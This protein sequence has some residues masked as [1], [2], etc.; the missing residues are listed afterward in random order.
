VLIEN[1]NRLSIKAKTLFSSKSL[2]LIVAFISIFNILT[3][4]SVA[5]E[6]SSDL[7]LLEDITN[8]SDLFDEGFW[9]LKHLPEGF[10]PE[11][12]M[13]RPRIGLALSGGGARGLA[14]IG[15]L[16]VL[17]EEKIPIDIIVGTSMGGVIA[18]LYSVGYLPSQIEGLTNDVDWGKLFSD[19]PSRRNL[20]LA[21]KEIS[22]QDLISLR[23]RNGKPYIPDALVTGETL[24]TE[25]L[26]LTMNAPYSNVGSEFS[27]M[28]NSLGL[29]ATDLIRGERVLIDSGDL[30]LALRATMAVPILFRALRFDGK[31]MVDG[32]AMENIPVQSAR[33]LGADIIVAVDCSTPATPDLDPDLPWEIANQVTTL[34]SAL[35]DSLS[36]KSANVLI[37]P[38][39]TNLGSADFD[40]VS[41]LIDVGREAGKLYSD[42]IRELMPEAVA[43]PQVWT[44]VNAL[45]LTFKNPT[46]R[47]MVPEQ[48]GLTL[49]F[50]TT[51][52]INAGLTNLLKGLR[53]WDFGAARINTYLSSD[54][55]LNV[56]VDLGEV[57]E[58]RVTGI[59]GNHLPSILREMRVKE[60][61][62]LKTSE[63]IASIHQVH[64][65]GRYTT[66]F[67][68]LKK[69]PDHG[70]I[71][72]MLLEEAPLPRLGLG[73]GYDTDR[74][75]RYSG[76]L[77]IENPVKFI[78]SD[79]IVLRA[80]YGDKDRSY[81][82]NLRADRLAKTYIGWR[83]GIEYIETE[84]DIFNSDGNSIR[85][86]D[87][88]ALRT[89]LETMFNLKTWGSLSVGF[90]SERIA[91][92]LEDRKRKMFNN[93]VM[94]RATLD[95]EDRRPFP[96]SGTYL[97]FRYDTYI[98]TG[99]ENNFNTVG[100]KL[101]VVTPVAKRTTFRI[102]FNGGISDDTTPI[103]HQF[104]IGGVQTFPAF[105]PFRFTA[106]RYIHATGAL[107]Y[108]LI[109][110]MISETY[111]LARYDIAAFNDQR[112]WRPRK[113]DLIQ[114]FSIGIA[115]D[116]YIGP[117]ELWGAFSPE[118]DTSPK[119]ERIFVN[120]GYYFK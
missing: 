16:Q 15:V 59:P 33:D 73:L 84:R 11:L 32:G 120:L 56:Q 10:L 90:G 42:K 88:W 6:N 34:M 76:R 24:F 30:A 60:G 27:V 99:G 75:S 29:V 102:A 103:T 2:L 21:Q 36:R 52:S 105:L 109:S 22:N 63:L 55:I 14:H 79:E 25:I 67:C 110:R 46:Y 85:Q 3:S 28:K 20:F 71:L 26:R 4:Y 94:I 70:V 72:T 37:S 87:V 115:L 43:P 93:I 51:A 18:S 101:E 118:S 108:D 74:N 116:T 104:S 68:Y 58:I 38:E 54:G 47:K 82:L 44:T 23:F 39:L 86:G 117:L 69:H 89:K 98:V 9:Q 78:G 13:V 114:S 40:K 66:V 91:D 100:L 48:I 113:E 95:T 49:G 41:E 45:N 17:H 35:N 12:E 112:N 80:I 107:R 77:A 62:P 31:L 64:A 83:G 92:N 7:V 97:D 53:K 8:S 106:L 81:V 119:E 111:L 65:T 96:N 1:R 19:A 5:Q 61:Y 57:R 50:R